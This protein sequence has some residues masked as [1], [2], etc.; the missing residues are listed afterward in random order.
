MKT[1]KAIITGILG[2]TLILMQFTIHAQK[3][4]K[5]FL[6]K[7]GHI[8]YQIEGDSEGTKTVWFDDYGRKYSEETKATTTTKFFGMKNTE[9]EHDIYIMKGLDYISVDMLKN[10]GTT[11]KLHLYEDSREIAENMTEEEMKQ[12]EE[13]I[14]ESFGGER[15]GTENFLGKPCEVIKVLGAKSWI[16]KGIILKSEMSSLGQKITESA[17]LIEEN[18]SVPSSVFEPPAGVE[19]SEFRSLHNIFKDIEED[20][21]DNDDVDEDKKPKSEENVDPAPLTYPFENF[22]K[23]VLNVEIE[24]YSRTSVME[25]DEEYLCVFMKSMDDAYSII[26][27]S[28]KD[29]NGVSLFDPNEFDHEEF[30]HDGL[31]MY[32]TKM[33]MDEDETEGSLLAVEYPDQTMIISIISTLKQDKNSLLKIADQLEL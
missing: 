15:L 19:L 13:D 7:S 8:E 16:Y 31:Q 26:A 28:S 21:E 2:I 30:K 22:E 29:V 12:L 23:A 27:T 17:T 4:N 1:K 3:E 18:V 9:E 25:I 24:G 20:M 14:L 5:R 33:Y 6:I 32:Y 11:G 10:E